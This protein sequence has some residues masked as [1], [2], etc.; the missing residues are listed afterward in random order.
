MGRDRLTACVCVVPFLSHQYRMRCLQLAVS[1]WRMVFIRYSGTV[2]LLWDAMRWGLVG[3][4]ALLDALVVVDRCCNVLKEN[5][6]R[7]RRTTL[8]TENVEYLSTYKGRNQTFPFY[9]LERRTRFLRRWWFTLLF[10]SRLRNNNCKDRGAFIL[11]LSNHNYKL[12]A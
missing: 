7:V 4:H 2:F 1:F 9:T 6:F 11:Y 3:G 12:G 10:I 5:G 8:W